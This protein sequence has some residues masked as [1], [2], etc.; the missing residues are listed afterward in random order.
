MRA[1]ALAIE[2]EELF[3]RYQDVQQ[4]VGWTNEDVER[5]RAA[6]AI[7]TPHFDELV[8]DFYAE[9]DRHPEAR[10]V[11]TGG[12][13]Q[14]ER[15]KGTLRTWLA[16]L[17]TGPYDTKYVARRWRVGLRHVEIGLDQVYTNAALS[18]I[19]DGLIRLLR[20]NWRKEQSELLVTVQSLNKLVNLDLA[21]IEDADN[22]H[23]LLEL[24]VVKR[25]DFEI[26]WRNTGRW[27][28]IHDIYGEM[29]LPFM[30][31][32]ALHYANMIEDETKR[33][34]QL[35]EA[36]AKLKGV[37]D[38]DLTAEGA[39]R[40]HNLMGRVLILQANLKKAQ[41]R[42]IA[43]ENAKKVQRKPGD[44][45]KPLV[46]PPLPALM[47][48]N[49][50]KAQKFINQA[51]AAKTRNPMIPFVGRLALSEAIAQS[52]QK[53][54][55]MTMLKQL[56]NDKLCEMLGYGLD[57]MVDLTVSDIQPGLATQDVM[58]QLC[59]PLL[60]QHSLTEDVPLKR[61]NGSTIYVDMSSFP[62]V[63]GNRAYLLD[64]FKEV[65]ERRWAQQQ[66]L[67]VLDQLRRA[68]SE[69]KEFVRVLQF[70]MKALLGRVSLWRDTVRQAEDPVQLEALVGRAERL[71]ALIS[72]VSQYSAI[73]TR[74]ETTLV[75][76]NDLVQKTISH[77]ALP[78][79]VEILTEGTWPVARFDRAKM[80]DVL[81]NLLANGV[82]SLR[83]GAGSIRL[84]CIEEASRYTLSVSDTGIGIDEQE[85]DRIF[86]M[87]YR[88]LDDMEE[89][90]RLGMGLT[91][92]K[93]SVEAWGG[94]IWVE[95]E[96]GTG[97]T[98]YFTVPKA[99]TMPTVNSALA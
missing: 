66:Q 71:G 29:Q 46:V 40:I 93:K 95:S 63:V 82:Q 91:V 72:T 20:D 56:A 52:G 45:P 30:Y 18:R 59:D 92:V 13:E 19:Q 89:A 35:D 49:Y 57:E 44:K 55:A 98:F 38:Q 81:Y 61:K 12:D 70:D 97:S 22:A 14:V 51:V 62:I 9:I 34:G 5:I 23:F 28:L 42:K 17:F 3:Q 79:G 78:E 77:L 75:D 47:Q 87:F 60:G 39:A 41:L 65:T 25:D 53:Q 58:E 27:R 8:E 83:E 68:N 48:A 67:Q 73:G 74:I 84:R 94:R 43:I 36:F 7:V 15:L 86:Q 80:T 1:K 2:P 33:P 64:I 99:D 90:D 76:L 21:M 6:S 54:Q 10:K 16:Q 96:V 26:Q 24:G 88:I 31:G 50:A 11:I 4:Y 69:L 37:A 85:Y 32:W